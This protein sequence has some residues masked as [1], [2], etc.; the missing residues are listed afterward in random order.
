[1]HNFRTGLSSVRQNSDLVGRG[2]GLRV[3]FRVGARSVGGVLEDRGA[4]CFGVSATGR[5]VPWL[6]A[7]TMS[8]TDDEGRR[9]DR[10]L[11]ASS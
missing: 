1:M 10:R 9:L 8:A 2:L 7:A 5:G 11:V 3:G 6:T 4:A